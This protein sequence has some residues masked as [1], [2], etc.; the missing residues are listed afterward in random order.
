VCEDITASSWS[1]VSAYLGV[2]VELQVFFWVR[3]DRLVHYMVYFE[4]EVI[5]G[6]VHTCQSCFVGE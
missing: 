3:S 1:V 6:L 2:S 4:P 5:S